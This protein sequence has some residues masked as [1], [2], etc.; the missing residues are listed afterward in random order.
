MKNEIKRQ[1]DLLENMIMFLR[2]DEI[3]PE[4]LEVQLC[5]I[6]RTLNRLAEECEE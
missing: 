3:E 1:A 5:E 2:Y 4:V 6:V